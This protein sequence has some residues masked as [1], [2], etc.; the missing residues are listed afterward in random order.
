VA[1]IGATTTTSKT[2]SSTRAQLDKFGDCIR[3][4]GLPEYQNPIKN[5]NSIT[6]AVQPGAQFATAEFECEHLLPSGLQPPSHTVTP[7]EQVYYLKVVACMQSHGFRDFPDPTFVG[8]TVHF[9]LPSS[10]DQNSP[11]FDRALT[12]CRTL[13]PAGLPYSN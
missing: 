7:A 10:V 6:M 2:P 8:G 5:G 4:H 11:L 1:S 12:T 9:V 13:I 3:S